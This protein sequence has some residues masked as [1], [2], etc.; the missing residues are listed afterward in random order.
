MP[1]KQLRSK[2]TQRPSGRSPAQQEKG[3]KVLT[4]DSVMSA[5]KRPRI[6]KDS[7]EASVELPPPI[8]VPDIIVGDC[9]PR[10]KE[11]G[12]VLLENFYKDGFA[13]TPEEKADMEAHLE[14]AVALFKT[15]YD[16]FKRNTQLSNL[17]HDA[18]FGV[19]T[20]RPLEGGSGLERNMYAGTCTSLTFE[21]VFWLLFFQ[22]CGNK[23]IFHSD[24]GQICGPNITSLVYA[25]FSKLKK[26]EKNDAESQGG[27]E[28]EDDNDYVPKNAPAVFAKLFGKIKR[29]P[30]DLPLTV[31]FT[32]YDDFPLY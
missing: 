21:M 7:K 10:W 24:I 30:A 5:A 31:F 22:Q 17:V 9:V 11:V 16:V 23:K 28:E 20:A 3:V 8:S 6:E 19:A 15:M 14:R 25:M 18:R 1:P 2:M 13:K 26:E 4:T 12:K 29:V 32:A 27:E